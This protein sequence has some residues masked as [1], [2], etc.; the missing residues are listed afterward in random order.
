[1]RGRAILAAAALSNLAAGAAEACSPRLGS[2]SERMKEAPLAVR[3][4]LRVDW[5]DR[6]SERLAGTAMLKVDECLRRAKSVARCPRGLTIRF[7]EP[8]DGINCPPE[9]TRAMFRSG[10]LNF[11]LLWGND[12]DGWQIGVARRQFDE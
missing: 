1:M 10:R 4:K 12:R 2:F 6:S 11:F 9:I 5:S 7:E 3:G 8:L